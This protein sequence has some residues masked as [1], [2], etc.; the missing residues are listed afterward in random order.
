MRTS[1][2]RQIWLFRPPGSN[3]MP[4]AGRCGHT[5]TALHST[6]CRK[7]ARTTMRDRFASVRAAAVITAVAVVAGVSGCTSPT[8]RSAPDPAANT[9]LGELT[10]A[11]Q[12]T[13]EG[14]EELLVKRCASA[15]R[16]VARGSTEWRGLRF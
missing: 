11:E 9:K 7:G 12:I 15:H 13:L 1:P 4:P 8:G 16:W 14:T 10:Y 3:V 5:R 6:A 2:L